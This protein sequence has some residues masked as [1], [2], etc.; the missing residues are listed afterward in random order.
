MTDFMAESKVVSIGTHILNKFELTLNHRQLTSPVNTSY[1]ITLG[2][3][4]TAKHIYNSYM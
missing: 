3:E 2:L 4:S 1:S